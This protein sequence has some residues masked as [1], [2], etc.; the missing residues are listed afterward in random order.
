MSQARVLVYSSLFPHQGD[1]NAGV[2]IRERMFR[3]AQHLPLVVVSPKPWF[4]G[5]TL[6]RMIRP[7]FRPDAPRHEKQDGIDVYYPRYLSFPG[8]F[9]S[10]DGMFMA[11]GSL[12][13]LL[14]LRKE[15]GFN[16]IDA[17]FA[18]PDGYAA[19]L[20]GRWL[21]L[22]VSITL[23]GSEV[24]HAKVAAKRKRIVS[25]L[26]NAKRVFSVSDSLKKFAVS[27]GIEPDKIRIVGNAVD[28]EKFHPVDRHEARRRFSLNANDPVLVS[29]GWLIER[30]GFHR[31][32]EC[33]PD[34]LQDYPTLQLVIVGG[35]SGTESMEPF[36]REQVRSLGLQEHVHF[37]GSMPSTEIKWPLSA[38][39]V[40]VLATRWEGWA[41]VL[42]EAMATGLPVVATDVGGNSEV[43]ASSALG[44]I[45][46]FG[47]QNAL[48]DA[49]R[50]ALAKQWD[51]GVL[52]NFAVNNCWEKRISILVKELELLC[53]DNMG[54]PT[55]N[56][57]SS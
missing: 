2:F 15:F 5:Q 24:V 54:M 37:L 57:H 8:L 38:A 13:T 49:L 41:N 18:Y 39:D 7:H 34:L 17:H 28:A 51:R 44:T 48:T 1:P 47:N 42:L 6:L 23:R 11:L 50:N 25:A 43:I 20:L 27:L 46:P 29:V 10:L 19:S 16:L 32:I 33:L 12:L 30:K 56:S 14:K 35:A 45:V 4:P 26:Q 22:P 52:R 53:Q 31:V 36:L 3:V 9:K 40:F 21:H 55:L